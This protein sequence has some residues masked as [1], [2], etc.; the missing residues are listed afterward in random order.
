MTAVAAAAS[1]HQR[2]RPVDQARHAPA[3]ARALLSAMRFGFQMNVAS[4]IEAIETAMRRPAANPAS[5]P[6]IERASHHVTPTAAIPASAMNATTA[7]GESPPFGRADG[8]RR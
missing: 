1:S 7:S 3:S 8:A 4:S 2:A 6:P 5:G